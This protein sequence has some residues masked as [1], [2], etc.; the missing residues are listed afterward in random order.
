M[1]MHGQL[2]YTALFYSAVL[3]VWGLYRVFRRMHLNASYWSAVIVGEALFA[4]Q[5]VLGVI[6][7]FS[8]QGNFGSRASHIVFGVLTVLTLPAIYFLIRRKVVRRPMLAFTLGFLFVVG[9]IM[10]G[11][12]IL[13]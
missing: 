3:A 5:G 10:G 13:N 7:I 1:E 12:N 8:S 2:G 4:L 9:T 11:I 6:R